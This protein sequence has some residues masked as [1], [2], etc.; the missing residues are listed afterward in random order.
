MS[1]TAVERLR[2]EEM[3]MDIL[4]KIL[5]TSMRSVRWVVKT[6]EFMVVRNKWLPKGG[7]I[8]TPIYEKAKQLRELLKDKDMYAKEEDFP[9]YISIVKDTVR[10]KINDL[11]FMSKHDIQ[12]QIQIDRQRLADSKKPKVVVSHLQE[13]KVTVETSEEVAIKDQWRLNLIAPMDDNEQGLYP[14]EMSTLCNLIDNEKYHWPYAM[15]LTA[16]IPLAHWIAS[17]E[18]SQLIFDGVL[19]INNLEHLAFLTEPTP[20]EMRRLTL[21]SPILKHRFLTPQQA[22]ELKLNAEG[23]RTLNNGALRARLQTL[24]F[25]DEDTELLYRLNVFQE[26]KEEI[27]EDLDLDP[28]DDHAPEDSSEDDALWEVAVPHRIKPN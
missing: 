21:L 16:N 11:R 20:H 27:E 13:H 3:V 24:P 26:E 6:L 25:S 12:K 9:E 28:Q 14:E 1:I 18:I 2:Y 7:H 17:P 15:L 23:I 5:I 8:P 4:N 22:V 19:D 10:S